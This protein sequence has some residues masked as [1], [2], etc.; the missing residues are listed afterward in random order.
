MK[1]DMDLIRNLLIEI[2][3]DKINDDQY[4]DRVLYHFE[5]LIQAG[6]IEGMT[7]LRSVDGGMSYGLHSPRLTWNGNEFLDTIRK[8]SV[9]EKI[10]K[11]TNDKGVELTIDA[12]K[13]AAPSVIGA[14]LGSK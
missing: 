3:D 8:K 7:I 13:M 9:W 5:L 11:F 12:I 6:F 14:M 4:D 1:R 2:S 10:K